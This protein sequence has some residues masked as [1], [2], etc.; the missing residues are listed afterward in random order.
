MKL[1]FVQL[2]FTNLILSG[3][4]AVFVSPKMESKGEE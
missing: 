1:D 3:E 2:L 4:G